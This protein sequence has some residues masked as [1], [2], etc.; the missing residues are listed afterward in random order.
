MQQDLPNKNAIHYLAEIDNLKGSLAAAEAERD[1][2]ENKLEM[3]IQ[4]KNAAEARAE[5]AEK[6]VADIKYAAHMPED[7]E[8]GLPSW[9]CQ[10]LYA[11]YIYQA[12]NQQEWDALKRALDERD[13]LRAALEA[14]RDWRFDI[15]GDC[16]AEAQALAR[17]ALGGEAKPSI[18]EEAAYL[19]SHHYTTC[20]CADCNRVRASLAS[21]GAE[22]E[23]D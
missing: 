11:A 4:L 23:H 21:R 8:Y 12:R 9:I 15:S 22:D 14:V 6:E 19:A 17:A 2:A 18:E 20:T 16:V 7:Y 5:E 3:V 10:R 13:Q 1:S